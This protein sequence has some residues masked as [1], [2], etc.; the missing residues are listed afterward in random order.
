MFNVYKISIDNPIYGP[1]K[2][3][4]IWFRGCSIRCKGCINPELWEKS[5]INEMN[6]TDLLSN[7]KN[8]DVT[9]LGGE[10]LEQDDLERFIDELVRRNI[11]IILF[12]G[13]SLSNMGTNKLRVCSKCDVVISEPFDEKLKDDSLYLRG[14]KNQII[15]FNSKRYNESDFFKKTNELSIKIEGNSVESFGRNKIIIEELLDLK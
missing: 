2:R 6:L 11:G 14:S 9:L 12:T 8:D 4:V 15:S 1:G 13:Y 10:P 5:S 3:T 7:I